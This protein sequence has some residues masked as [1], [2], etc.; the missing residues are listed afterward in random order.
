MRKMIVGLALAGLA[1]GCS[2]GALSAANKT[3]TLTLNPKEGQ[4]YSYNLTTGAG[5]QNISMDMTMTAQKV[6]A[7]QVT[8]ETKLSNMMMAGKPAPGAT[9]ETIQLLL[10]K[11][12]KPISGTIEAGAGA[13]TK[14]SGDD[15]SVPTPRLPAN[16]VKIGDTWTVQEKTGSTVYKLTSVGNEGGKQ[17]AHIEMTGPAAGQ[18]KL[19]GPADFVVD[20]DTGMPISLQMTADGPMGKT[21][22]SMKQTS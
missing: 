12:S 17:V 20:V 13:G 18:T 8:F 5:G 2:G 21:T 3:Y 11:Q 15:A 22:T 19:D 1:V 14:I 7:N 6:E 10:D 9:D 16:P 4:T